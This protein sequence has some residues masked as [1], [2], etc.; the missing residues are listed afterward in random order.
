MGGTHYSNREMFYTRARTHKHNQTQDCALFRYKWKCR[1]LMER[2]RNVSLMP[3]TDNLALA[4][5]YNGTG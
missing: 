5:E 2:M 4:W 1:H 3:K